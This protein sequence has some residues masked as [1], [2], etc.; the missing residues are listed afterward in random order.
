MAKALAMNPDL[1]LFDEVMGG[2]N[3]AEID[4]AIGIINLTNG[5]WFWQRFSAVW[6][7]ASSSQVPR[8]CPHWV[9]ALSL[10][11][12]I[13]IWES[14]FYRESGLSESPCLSHPRGTSKPGFRRGIPSGLFCIPCL[15]TGIGMLRRI[16]CLT[17]C[18]R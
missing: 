8:F 10:Q 3:H 9:S 15:E 6:L 11:P 18:I 7:E 13:A 2:L 17:W 14:E 4:F 1:I 16:S 12:G 5:V